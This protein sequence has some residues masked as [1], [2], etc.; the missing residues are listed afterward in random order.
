SA[1][2]GGDVEGRLE[3]YHYAPGAFLFGSDKG[4]GTPMADDKG[5]ARA[6]EGEGALL[7][8]RRLEAKRSSAK[9]CTFETNALDLAPG[10][11][12]SVLDHPRSDLAEDKRLLIV[13]STLEGTSYGPW[14][15][16]CEARSADVPYRPALS[17]PKPKIAGVESATVVGRAGEEIHT[18]EFGRVRV[19]FHW[20]REGTMDDDSSCW[21]HV[22]QPWGGAGF[23]AV[24][25]PRVGQ[26]V[27]VDFLGG[28]PDRPI[29]T[30]RVFNNVQKVP[31]ALPANKTQSGWK[32]SST[33]NT[34][35]YNE[36]MFADLSGRELVRMQAERDLTKLVKHDEQGTVGRNRTRVVKND[37]KITVG[38][39]REKLVENDETLT[40]GRN[41]VKIV[42]NDESVDIGH[43]RVKVIKN[44]EN[45]DV[46]H[47]RVKIVKNDEH[48]TI[49]Q[50]RTTTIGRNRTKIV[51][52]D[53]H[54]TIGGSRTRAVKN[55]ESVNIGG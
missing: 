16:R 20:D 40:T 18:D 19:H 41:R 50:D 53:E 29:I 1:A 35:G 17:T 5:K 26:E 14:S 7:A 21:I 8:A 28:D 23:G 2:A 15:H 55:D 3:R 34:G 39:D 47:D 46:G 48:V 30:G 42:K 54:V 33:G 24:N 43:N 36:I 49:G 44:D 6:D 11:V 51:K 38:R 37:E 12:I 25:L 22:S 32:S 9:T 13:A 27:I 31:Y 52:N 45:V 10:V 4:G